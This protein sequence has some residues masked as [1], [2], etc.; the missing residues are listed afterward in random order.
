MKCTFGART[1][2]RK[3]YRDGPARSP[4]PKS[5]SVMAEEQTELTD[6]SKLLPS[7]LKPH[8]SGTL[9][10]ISGDASE[11][12]ESLSAYVRYIDRVVKGNTRQLIAQSMANAP[13]NPE[14]RH[15]PLCFCWPRRDLPESDDKSLVEIFTSH[16]QAALL[17]E[18]SVA[19]TGFAFSRSVRPQWTKSATLTELLWELVTF[20]FAWPFILVSHTASKRHREMVDFLNDAVAPD[21]GRV[22]VN[23][24]RS[25][26][27]EAFVGEQTYNVT[28]AGVHRPHDAKPDK[29]SLSGR[30]LRKALDPYDDQTFAYVYGVAKMRL[31]ELRTEC[32]VQSIGTLIDHAF[33]SENRRRS[34]PPSVDY[35]QSNRMVVVSASKDIVEFSRRLDIIRLL[36]LLTEKLR[37]EA[38]TAPYLYAPPEGVN[39][40]SSEITDERIHDVNEPFEA[41]F[42]ADPEEYQNKERDDLAHALKEWHEHGDLSP[43]KLMKDSLGGVTCVS[44]PIRLKTQ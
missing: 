17:G 8:L 6:E 11:W 9:W 26:L 37:E 14:I 31:D 35:G 24:P 2:S 23:T 7:E 29:K 30:D 15:L 32:K 43:E 34:S 40:L 22:I 44:D 28:L 20:N 1:R 18:A 36:L 21:S 25:L 4:S 39:Y 12:T 33:P 42:N 13:E 16:H 38:P 10:R 41:K 5:A 19:I 27:D 3:A